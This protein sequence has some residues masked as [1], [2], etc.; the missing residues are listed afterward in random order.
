MNSLFANNTNTSSLTPTYT[1]NTSL[2][3][4]PSPSA[5]STLDK[6]LISL[7]IASVALGACALFMWSCGY[8]VNRCYRK[9]YSEHG[10][11]L[12]E[13]EQAPLRRSP[14]CVGAARV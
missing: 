7:A 9:S 6:I 11:Q 10:K 13:K 4:S 8:C 3:S 1:Y 12:F 14:A 2:I 5:L